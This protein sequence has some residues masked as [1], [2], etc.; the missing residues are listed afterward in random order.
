MGEDHYLSIVLTVKRKLRSIMGL[1]R[2]LWEAIESNPDCLDTCP[3]S[4]KCVEMGECF[5]EGEMRR[6]GLL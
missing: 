2:L 1:C 5:L 3:H 4:E 6:S